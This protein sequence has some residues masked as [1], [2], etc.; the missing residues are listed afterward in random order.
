[1]KLYKNLSLAGLKSIIN[2]KTFIIIASLIVGIFSGLAAVVLKNTVR[3]IHT[4][5]HEL[6][7]NLTAMAIKFFL[8]MFGIVLSV[9][10]VNIFLKGKFSRGLS[11]IIYSIVKRASDLPVHKTYT[12]M[13]TS[14]FTV[15]LGGSAGLEAPIVVTGAAIGSNVAKKLQLNIQIRTLLLAC[16]SAAGISAIFNSPIAG[17]IFA[18]EVLLPDL[19]I[20]YFIPL[21]IS[22]AASAVVSKFLYSGQLFFLVTGGWQMNAIPFYIMLGIFCGFVSIYMIRTTIYIENYLHKFK[23]S[24][25]KA[26]LG[27]LVLCALIFIL[28][29]LFGEGYDTIS[30]LL[31]L[32]YKTL[33]ENGLY[34]KLGQNEF[35]ILGIIFLSVFVKVIATSLTMGS[36]GNGGII[37][38]SLLVGALAGFFLARVMT[39]L[40]IANLN[41]VNF[42]AVGMAGILSGVIHAPLTGIFLIAEITGGYV[43]I[44]PLM[45]V[46]A[47]SYFISR[48]FQGESVYTSVLAKQGIHFRSNKEKVLAHQFNLT[49][50][51][52]PNIKIVR[53]TDSLRKLIEIISN[54]R[55]NIYPVINEN[56]R[57]A[58][59]INLDDIREILLNSELYDIVLAYEIMNKDFLT[60]NINEPFDIV[61]KIFEENKMYSLPV[62]ENGEYAGLINKSEA[63]NKY[64]ALLLNEHDNIL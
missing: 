57:I 50:I 62:V 10:F 61:I 7:Q 51:I 30:G 25:K 39:L 60:V 47:L 2:E 1:M 34:S 17:V 38:P 27:G 8:P 24:Y 42:L 44:V 41:H 46:T 29:P 16:G 21:L 64:A 28:P 19:S 20:P 45:I 4:I 6:P 14:A 33:F 35:L 54:S 18:F 15:G 59:I 22:S 58:G 53:P 36:G 40:H 37:A 3:Y 49:E 63:F 12:H 9:L 26:I 32:N 48:H 52:E 5:T 43:L 13:I 56:N 31:V 23:N 11:N 55:Q